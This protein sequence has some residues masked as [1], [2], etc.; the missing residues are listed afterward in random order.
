M[1]LRRSREKG[2]GVTLGND[3]GIRKIHLRDK[4]KLKFG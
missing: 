1:V 2:Q 4:D 3:E